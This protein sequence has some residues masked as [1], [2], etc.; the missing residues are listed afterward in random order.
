MRVY[1]VRRGKFTGEHYIFEG[2]EEFQS[3]FP[4]SKVK[5]WGDI[6]IQPNDWVRADDG[7]ILQCLH[8]AT[9]INK[10]KQVTHLYRFCNG[11]FAVTEGKN[12]LKPRNFYGADSKRKGGFGNGSSKDKQFVMMVKAGYNYTTAFEKAYGHK[13][14]D[15][16]LR[17]AIDRNAGEIME[18]LKQRLETVNER[19][20][21]VTG[22]TVSEIVDEKLVQLAANL[23]NTNSM[24]EI[25]ESIKFLKWYEM[26]AKKNIKPEEEGEEKPPLLEGENA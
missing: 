23:R 4:S 19:V 17:K 24:K 18:D 11:S 21:Q 25:R 5:K 8:K 1:T 12:G 14:T 15:F 7:Y 10:W 6:S 3:Y 2:E 26:E 13:C 16:K 22:M 20:K 9:L